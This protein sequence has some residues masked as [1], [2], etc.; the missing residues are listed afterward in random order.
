MHRFA[1]TTDVIR[2]ME[3]ILGLASLSH[4]D[5][6]GRPLRDVWAA[7]PDLAPYTALTPEQ[8]LDELNPAATALARASARLDLRQEDVADEDLFNH[9]LW[10]AIKGPGVPYPAL[11]RVPAAE[12]MG[13]GR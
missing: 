11:T 1:N 8:P 2:T 12:V 10:E 5:G 3:E 13:G 4:F 6:F 7:E 9:I